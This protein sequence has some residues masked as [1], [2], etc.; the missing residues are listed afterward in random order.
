[1]YRVLGPSPLYEL[2]QHLLEPW[3][4]TGAPVL[5]DWA[6]AY[7]RLLHAISPK[8]PSQPGPGIEFV[9]DESI[10][11]CLVEAFYNPS[12]LDDLPFYRDSTYFD[13]DPEMRKCGH[14]EAHDVAARIKGFFGIDPGFW[15]L[16][17]FLVTFIMCPTTRFATGGTDS[18]AIGAIFIS[19][20]NTYSDHDLYELL[21]HEFTHTAM[22]LDE[23]VRPHYGD[24][25][26]L[27][28]PKNYGLAA[29]SGLYR[30]LDKVLHSLVVSTEVLLHRHEV[31]GHPADSRIH[32]PS[33]VLRE[34]ALRAAD[35]LLSLAGRDQLL[36]S[37]GLWLTHRCADLIDSTWGT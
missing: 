2:L 14:L 35:S 24:E 22:F 25:A 23:L 4:D 10:E 33:P 13:V 12:T 31:I 7:A 18:A 1:M 30:P 32:P 3:L 27:P 20:P 28:D 34:G 36:G 17:Q 29:I 8:V 37:R 6:M 9:M 15:A 16:F 26:L 5:E 21:I 19:Q 11:K